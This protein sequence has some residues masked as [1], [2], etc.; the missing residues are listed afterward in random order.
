VVPRRC[1]IVPE[2]PPPRDARGRCVKRRY[3]DAISRFLELLE[4]VFDFAQSGGTLIR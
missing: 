2:A 1:A 4:A 3:A